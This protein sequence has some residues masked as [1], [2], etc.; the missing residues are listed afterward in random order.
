MDFSHTIL[1]HKFPHIKNQWNQPA[2]NPQLVRK[3]RPLTEWLKSFRPKHHYLVATGCNRSKVARCWNHGSS[4]LTFWKWNLSSNLSTFSGWNAWNE[5]AFQP[6]N[7]LVTRKVSFWHLPLHPK[8]AKPRDFHPQGAFC[9]FL[10]AGCPKWGTGKHHS[11]EM[12]W[13]VW[14]FFLKISPPPP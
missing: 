5:N 3:K 9:R 14:L 6:A 2:R 11:I 4:Q 8:S 1:Q 10:V 12:C 13:Y 7:M